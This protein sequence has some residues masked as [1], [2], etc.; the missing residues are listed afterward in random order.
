MAEGTKGGMAG[1]VTVKAGSAEELT[2]K[3]GELLA[4]TP[5]GTVICSVKAG[6][7]LNKEE[8][9]KEEAQRLSATVKKWN[10]I[11]RGHTLRTPHSRMARKS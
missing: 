6:V 8:P 11:A 1:F 10:K 3:L 4:E 9:T 2:R 7:I 5:E